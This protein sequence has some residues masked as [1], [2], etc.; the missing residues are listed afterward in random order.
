MCGRVN[1][2]SIKNLLAGAIKAFPGHMLS[3]LFCLVLDLP[4]VTSNHHN[5]YSATHSLNEAAVEKEQII[6][7]KR[8]TLERFPLAK[9]GHVQQRTYGWQGRLPRALSEST[10]LKT[11]I[12]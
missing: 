6:A 7:G 5:H 8:Q 10:L 2:V 9:E 11:L 4:T 3:D 12:M 1:A